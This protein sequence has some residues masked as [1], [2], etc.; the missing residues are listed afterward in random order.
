MHKSAVAREHVPPERLCIII[1][2]EINICRTKPTFASTKYSYLTVRGQDLWAHPLQFTI[3][4]NDG[5]NSKV[6]PAMI[7]DSMEIRLLEKVLWK[8]GVY[9]A[10][11]WKRSL[12]IRLGSCTVR[13]DECA[14]SVVSMHLENGCGIDGGLGDGSILEVSTE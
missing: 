6:W 11:Y 10:V 7:L 8:G 1:W 5:P 4:E 3:I 13:C 14:W 9:M 2:C 12:L